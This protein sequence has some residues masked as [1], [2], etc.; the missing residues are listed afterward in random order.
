MVPLSDTGNPP[1]G[2]IPRIVSTENGDDLVHLGNKDVDF[3]H[4]HSSLEQEGSNLEGW[5]E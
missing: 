4:C 1:G 5:I 3:R 2:V